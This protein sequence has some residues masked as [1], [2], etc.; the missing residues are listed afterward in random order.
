M[1]FQV[2][3]ALTSLLVLTATLRTASAGKEDCPVC[4]GALEKLFE[5]VEN[6]SDMVW[7]RVVEIGFFVRV[8]LEEKSSKE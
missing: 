4:N 5:T 1:G 2:A 7:S 8:C 6:K 3:A